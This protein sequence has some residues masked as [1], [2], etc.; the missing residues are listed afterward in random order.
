MLRLATL[1]AILGLM[2]VSKAVD[3]A[4][5]I[6]SSVKTDDRATFCMEGEKVWYYEYTFRPSGNDINK[7]ERKELVI[8][9]DNNI[10]TWVDAGIG[11]F[12]VKLGKSLGEKQVSSHFIH[13]HFHS[14]ESVRESL[15]I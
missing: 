10:T 14:I 12:T 7:W 2:S 9:P 4:E 1:I 8:G 11:K 15:L 13:F 6:I 3:P 5:I